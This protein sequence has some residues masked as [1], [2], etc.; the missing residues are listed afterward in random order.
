[1]ELQSILAEKANELKGEVMIFELAQC[2]QVFLHEHNKPATKSFYDEMVIRQQ[3][4]EQLEKE[5]KQIEKDREVTKKASISFS[6]CA[7]QLLQLR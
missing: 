5:A 4:K 2:V 1:M 3:Q 7:N 6:F